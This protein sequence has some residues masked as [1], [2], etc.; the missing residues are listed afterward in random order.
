M[1]IQLRYGRNG[2][3]VNVPDRNLAQVLRYNSVE[4]LADPRQATAQALKEPIG[5][6]PLAEVARGKSDAVIVVSDVTRPVPNKEILPPILRCLE[7]AGIPRNR[8]LILI[9]TGL[10]RPST[11]AE[12]DE[13]LGQEIIAAYRIEDHHARNPDEHELVGRTSDGVDAWIDRRYVRAGLKIL[14]ALVEPH[15][16]AGY[17]GGRKAIC[18]G[19]AATETIMAFH[20]PRLLE[21]PRATEGVIEGNPVHRFALE[22]ARMAGVD[23]TVNVTI[24]EQRRL[25]GVFAGGLEAAHAAAVAYVENVVR[26]AMPEPVDIVVTTAAGYPLDLTFYQSVKGLTA[27][28]PAVKSGGTIIMASECAEGIGSPECEE[29]LLSIES[30]E[31][32]VE[33][34]WD[35]AQA[36]IDQWQ[37]EEQAKV[38]R[39]AEVF[40]YCDGIPREKLARLFVKPIESVEAGIQE[41]IRK[42]GPDARIAVIPE[43]PYVLPTIRR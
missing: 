36:V 21:D 42:H 22:V 2:L 13:M 35:P 41:A 15:L 19:L 31:K 14:T 23:F 11:P 40:M 4:P 9:A 34:M 37:F 38:L 26:V 24:D 33:R 6:P 3:Q 5:A 27:A 32:A 18:P 39:K 43:G 30:P 25:T 8:I 16:M 28:L 1:R 10:H 29:Y 17:S 12:R 20:S 7:E